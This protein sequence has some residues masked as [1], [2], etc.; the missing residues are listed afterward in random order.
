MPTY[1]KTSGKRIQTRRQANQAKDRAANA[2]VKERS[3][4]RC[5]VVVEV[6]VGASYGR[7]RCERASNAIH[8]LI[9]G[10]GQRGIGESVKAERKLDVCNICHRDIHGGVGGKKLIRIGGVVP[11]YTDRYRR[12]A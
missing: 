9:S 5:E 8:H 7:F 4:G 6:Y 12:V 1:P 3:G 11:H 2:L 10:R